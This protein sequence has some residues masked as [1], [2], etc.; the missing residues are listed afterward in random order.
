MQYH[1]PSHLSNG[2]DNSSTVGNIV[3]GQPSGGQEGVTTE[4]I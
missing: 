3:L 4:V 2:N 1:L